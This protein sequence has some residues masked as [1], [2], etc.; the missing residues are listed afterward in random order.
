MICRRPS[1]QQLVAA[2]EALEHQIDALGPC[3]FGEK[4]FARTQMPH[5]VHGTRQG[6][7]SASESVANFPSF[8]MSLD[9]ILQCSS[10]TPHSRPKAHL[11]PQMTH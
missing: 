4:I 1:G 9:I 6:T 11:R 3:I 7:L 10:Q 5:R 2:G 8:R